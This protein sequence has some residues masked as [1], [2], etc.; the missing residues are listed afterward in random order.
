MSPIARVRQP[1]GVG[2]Y[3]ASAPVRLPAVG[4]LGED[5]DGGAPVPF[6][7]SGPGE[8]RRRY[9]LV[10]HPDRTRASTTRKRGRWP[11]GGT[12]CPPSRSP[13]IRPHRCGSCDART[14]IIGLTVVLLA[15]AAQRPPPAP[16]VLVMPP[17]R[18]SVLRARGHGPG[19][20]GVHRPLRGVRR[21]ARRGRSRR[22][23]SPYQMGSRRVR[24]KNGEGDV[25]QAYISQI[26]AAGACA[27][28]ASACARRRIR[29]RLQRGQS[30]GERLPLRRARIGGRATATREGPQ[31]VRFFG[32]DARAWKLRRLQRPSPEPGRGG[33]RA[34]RRVPAL[35]VG[36]RGPRLRRQPAR[37]GERP[38]GRARALALP[39]AASTATPRSTA[40]GA[41]T[42]P[43]P[44]RPGYHDYSTGFRC[45][46][47]SALS[48][49]PGGGPR[50]DG[51][52]GAC[53]RSSG[54]WS[55]GG[56]RPATARRPSASSA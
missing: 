36:L 15:C 16:T 37:V 3:P 33:A 53:A 26:Q 23:H 19:R 35:R 51:G 50:D 38:A 20:Q 32:P 8:A 12:P 1:E 56:L 42:S 22:P 17:P 29:A 46:V 44:T 27:R 2:L 41:S 55:R 11:G 21:R 28:P 54:P 24:A 4:V 10:R 39:A 25:P 6:A 7:R 43:T 14:G 45:C 34:V 13:G 47:E 52:A 40:T 5:L 31:M 48:A 9:R 18:P 30:R 49:S